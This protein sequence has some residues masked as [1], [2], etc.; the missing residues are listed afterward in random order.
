MTESNEIPEGVNAGD[1]AREEV[2]DETTVERRQDQTSQTFILNQTTSSMV[3]PEETVLQSEEENNVAI[4]NRHEL[5]DSN[6][7]SRDP[8]ADNLLGQDF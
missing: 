4:L 6:S 3:Y 7:G 8:Q 2:Q 1:M 5:N